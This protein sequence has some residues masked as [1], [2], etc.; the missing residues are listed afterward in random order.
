MCD[1]EGSKEQIK[2]IYHKR[3]QI[4]KILGEGGMG[5]VFLAEDMKTEQKVAVKIIKDQNQ[6]E[7]EREILKKLKDIKGVPKLFFAGKEEED[8]LVMEYIPGVSMK[9]YI[10]DRGKLKNKN[11]MLW[12]MKVCKVLEKIHK[13]GIIHMD[14]KPGNIILHPSGEIYL[15]DFGVSLTEGER[16]TG[17][18]TKIYASKKQAK[19]GK[20]A[21]FLMDIYSIGK[22]IELNTKNGCSRDMK[23]II[24]K[25]LKEDEIQ[26]YQRVGEI[27]KDLRNSL[28]KRKARFGAL[29]L[30]CAG[31][32]C[33][34]R[35]TDFKEQPSNV[36]MKQ[37]SVQS[38]FEKGML[39]FYGND[40]TQKDLMIAEQYFRK[41][42]ENQQK[43][44]AYL[45]LIDQL[46]EQKQEAT[47]EDLERVFKICE[48]DV[49]DF[50]SAYFFEHYYTIWSEKFSKDS[51]KWAET[52]LDKMRDQK[53]DDKKQ[54][55]LDTERL[56]L[57]E[58]MA[59]KGD[60]QKFLKETN[61]V[62]HKK[63]EGKQAWEIYDRRIL[64]LEERG[65][66]LEKEFDLFLRYYP[67]V[68]EAYIEYGIYL[69]Q[70]DQI[71]K[72]K[73]IYQKGKRQ[74]GM[75]NKRAQGLRRK[76]GL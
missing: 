54:Q 53:L 1:R 24:E 12:M 59:H 19:M 71:E 17:Y 9:K 34:L 30:V 10:E 8:F 11:M 69:C 2:R 74:T 49:H 20:K 26:G 57:Y 38:E 22:I 46:S 61:S 4:Q 39:F 58:V 16:L 33:Y 75:N 42:K 21:T 32:I 44:D 66:H 5:K 65:M 3:Y 50:W 23:K 48:E 63:M 27:R 15:I 67:K 64:Y 41:E 43:V 73:E 60:D 76:L 13:K 55:I 45:L 62:L 31:G 56:N 29:F 36:S 70:N 6:W 40:H 14:L 51:L 68:M 18:G 25:C 52:M 47:N 37:E 72:A 7:R 35:F 28:F